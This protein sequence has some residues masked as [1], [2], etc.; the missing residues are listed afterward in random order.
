MEDVLAKSGSEYGRVTFY[1]ECFIYQIIVYHS[2]DPDEQNNVEYSLN[3]CF[4][5]Y[6]AS[7]ILRFFF[8]L[9]V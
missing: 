9:D 8:S 1:Y 4:Q 3:I 5:S 7:F 6:S 2:D